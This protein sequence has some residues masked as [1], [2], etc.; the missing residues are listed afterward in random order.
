MV[1]LQFTSRVR[2]PMMVLLGKDG[3]VEGPVQFGMS[4]LPA[5]YKASLRARVNKLLAP[6]VDGDD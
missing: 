2:L 6:R 4:S 1:F 5:D 3:K